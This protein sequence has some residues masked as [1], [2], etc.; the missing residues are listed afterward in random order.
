M[1]EEDENVRPISDRLPIDLTA[2]RSLVLRNA[3]ANDPDTAFLTVLHVLCLKP[4]YHYGV[5]VCVEIEAKS[6]AFGTVR[7]STGN[8]ASWAHDV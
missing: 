1:P 4:F 7:A 2:Y 5:D 3:L 6:I 8:S